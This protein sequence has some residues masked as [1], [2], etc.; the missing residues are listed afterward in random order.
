M[1][2][3][4]NESYNGF[5]LLKEQEVKEINS[6]ARVFE[7]EKT[8]AK[9]LSLKNDD[10]NKVFSISFRTPPNDST[11]LPHILEHS[12]L[13][14]SRK[15]PM[16]EP[17]VE[18]I[19]GS[20]QTF[21]N[22]MTFSD[23]TM[24][25]IASRNEADFFN[26]MDVYLDAVLYPN[27][28]NTPEILMQEG[29]HYHLENK[30]DKLKYK[31]VVYNEMKGAFSSPEGVLY[32]KIEESVLK[33]TI[34]ANE[35]GGDPEVIP[36]LTQEQ[37]LEFHKKY[38]HPSNSYIFLY[39]DGD[40]NKELEFINDKYLKNF[41]KI[42]VDS[43][44]VEQEP[45]K[46]QE[47]IEVEYS[48]SPEDKEDDKTYISLN[49][50]TGKST[51]RELTL[52]MGILE[53][54]LLET[55]GAP[56]KKA[57]VDANLGKD[58]FGGFDDSIM[59]P[60]FSI[61][62]K[63]SNMDKVDKFKEVVND[64]LRKIVKEGLDKELIEACIN[65][66]EFKLREAEMGGAP[67]GLLY[68]ITCMK[69][70]LYDGDALTY[71]KYDEELK[72]IKS[73]LTTDYFEKLIEKYLLNN[74]HS[75]LLV[76]KPK[77]GL[78]EEKAAQLQDKLDAYKASLTEE[79]INKIVEETHNLI[80]RQSSADSKEVLET[81]PLLSLDDINKEPEM[82][83]QEVKEIGR[84]KVL[85]H[86]I[87][88]SEIAYV[89]MIFDASKVEEE[90]I[91]YVSILSQILGKVS[92][93]N[94]HYSKL[95]NDINI[96]TGGISYSIDA[97]AKNDND[98]ILYPKFTV[99]AKVLS[100][101][102]S[103]LVE[104]LNEVIIST[105]YDDS[106]RIKELIQEIKSRVEMTIFDRG[107]SVAASRLASYFSP[108]GCYN[109]KVSGLHFYKFISHL[110]RNF[111]AMKDE[112]LSNIEKVA[113]RIFNKNDLI[114]SI[115]GEEKEYKA[116]EKSISKVVDNL[117]D[118][119]LPDQKYSFKEVRDNE[120]LKTPGNVQYV[121]KGYNYRRLGAE[122]SGKMLV[123]KTVTSLDYL[124]NKVRVQGGA[125]GCM[126]RLTR[127]GNLIFVSYRDPN[128]KE[129][130]TAYDETADY[131]RELEISDRE[132]RKYI[133]GTISELDAPLSPALKGDRGAANYIRHLS[134][135][136]M[137]KEREEVL[138]TTQND[139]KELANIFEDVMRKEYYCA[140]GNESKIDECKDV[141]NKFMTV[142]E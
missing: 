119:A 67:K 21:L 23:K 52:A 64:T 39:G 54:M 11:G 141:F 68:G 112:I 132:M 53:Y 99:R 81:I 102:M 105:K 101:K 59:H 104:L 16:K 49:Y 76:L 14:G 107:H 74:T 69:S 75:S 19:K 123:L 88:T 118:K 134:F 25:P 124:W 17:F 106:A 65:I 58:I 126:I 73:A 57:L 3:K 94:K 36:D 85:H 8:G 5:K 43:Q 31:G 135:E 66:K 42:Q 92:T 32:R 61:V 9:L 47:K 80:K 121:A 15:F 111:D 51:D 79:E 56:L 130:M 13:C 20:L 129:T 63:N 100:D 90:L 45:Y 131:M 2:F 71:L 29:W 55:P 120:G 127:S 113:D 78:A 37:F 6:I 86:N 125:Y 35:S 96:N 116:F 82:I 70:W 44:I 26:L 103:Q 133:I 48:I 33:D 91:P 62:A 7:H 28:Y 136:D 138:S 95:A 87:F 60:V 27:I 1:S 46:E 98:T 84:T 89:N 4:I 142:F 40:L 12:V 77:K 115:T 18:L 72:N 34:Y 41:E 30:D 38:Y 137:K 10:D 50:V 108:A 110:E 24:Y 128:L 22:A 97:Y 114:L 109:E 139:I 93:E 117:S 140:L 122:Y 83:P